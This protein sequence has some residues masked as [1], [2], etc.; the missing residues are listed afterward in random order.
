MT[1]QWNK[2]IIFKFLSLQTVNDNPSQDLKVKKFFTWF[3]RILS[4]CKIFIKS[5]YSFDKYIYID[6]DCQTDSI[7]LFYFFNI[8]MKITNLAWR[9]TKLVLSR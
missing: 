4:E 2:I 5:I 6:F 1:V 3:V 9:Q 7:Q 8:V